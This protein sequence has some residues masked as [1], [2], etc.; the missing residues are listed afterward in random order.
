MKANQFFTIT[1]PREAAEARPASTS[2]AETF[3]PLFTE[4][5]VLD[6]IDY[7]ESPF[8]DFVREPLLP[9]K[10]S[11]RGFSMA[12]GDVDGDSVADL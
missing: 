4:S 5:D 12:W 6:G 1:E 8:D 10:L 9:R 11:Q 7:E 3:K 2:L